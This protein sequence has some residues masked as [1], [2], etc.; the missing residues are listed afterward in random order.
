VFSVDETVNY[1][2]AADGLPANATPLCTNGLPTPGVNGVDEIGNGV[3]VTFVREPGVGHVWPISTY[4]TVW[5]FFAAHPK[6]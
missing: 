2:L 5:N 4:A 3:E 6:P 1:W